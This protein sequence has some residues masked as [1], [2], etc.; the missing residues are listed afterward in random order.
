MHP[1]SPITQPSL[2]Y[3]YLNSCYLIIFFLSGFHQGLKLRCILISNNPQHGNNPTTIVYYCAQHSHNLPP[4]YFI[5]FSFPKFRWQSFPPRVFFLPPILFLFFFA[6]FHA[7]IYCPFLLVIVLLFFFLNINKLSHGFFLHFIMILTLPLFS[8]L[9][10]SNQQKKHRKQT[11]ILRTNQLNEEIDIGL[12]NP[13][14]CEVPP[15][16]KTTNYYLL[17]YIEP[18]PQN[19]YSKTIPY[20]LFVNF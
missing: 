15:T 11:H 9:S 8:L 12:R 2:L 20:T 1:C 16:L 7:Y 4:Q 6:F 10:F 17:L 14:S 18:I 3:S 19:L 5:S 13:K